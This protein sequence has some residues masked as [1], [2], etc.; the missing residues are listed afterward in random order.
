[1]SK[2]VEQLSEAE[3][4]VL[5]SENC[6]MCIEFHWTKLGRGVC[7][8][9]HKHIAHPLLHWCDRFTNKSC[10]VLDLEQ[11]R[12]MRYYMNTDGTLSDSNKDNEES[13]D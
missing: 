9:P 5:Q 4:L 7:R 2:K 13:C 1:M 10:G 6:S 3:K 11:R 12:S 8:E